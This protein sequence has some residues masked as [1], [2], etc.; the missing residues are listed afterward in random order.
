MYTGNETLYWQTTW[1]NAKAIN[2]GLYTL[3]A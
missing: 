1:F 2:G 3:K